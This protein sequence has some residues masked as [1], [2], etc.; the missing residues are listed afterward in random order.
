MAK[1]SGYQYP[2][3]EQRKSYIKYE[4]DITG[5]VMNSFGTAGRDSILGENPYQN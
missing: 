2:G 3:T 5:E 1:R 4:R